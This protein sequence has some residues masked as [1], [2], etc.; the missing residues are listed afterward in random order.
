[1]ACDVQHRLTLNSFLEDG[2]YAGHLFGWAA[3]EVLPIF[4]ASMAAAERVG[5]LVPGAR[6]GA[7]QF[8]FAEHVAAM[9]AYAR[10]PGSSAVPYRGDVTALMDDALRFIL[11]GFGLTEAAIEHHLAEESAPAPQAAV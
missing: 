1:M 5:D 10:L 4:V 9:I 3:E 6:F 2:G 11:R 8:W 7:N